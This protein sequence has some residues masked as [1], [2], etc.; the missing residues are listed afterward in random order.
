MKIFPYKVREKAA[1]MRAKVQ[2][3]EYAI[4]ATEWDIIRIKNHFEFIS[5]AINLILWPIKKRSPS[6]KLLPPAC[7]KT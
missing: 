3:I 7:P 1:I 2:S 5:L 4:W 6:S